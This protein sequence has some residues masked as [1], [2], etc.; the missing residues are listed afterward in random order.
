MV[1][2]H[3]EKENDMTTQTNQ[4]VPPAYVLYGVQG[5]GKD[6]TWIKI[7]AAWPNKDGKGFNI[8]C[9]AVPLAGRIVMRTNEPKRS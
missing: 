3:N 5:E 8:R 9:N 2:A 1:A 7:G 6:A 4:K